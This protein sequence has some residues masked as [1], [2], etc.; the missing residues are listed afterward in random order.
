MENPNSQNIG[1]VFEEV[2]GIFDRA[3]KAIWAEA[4]ERA[5]NRTQSEQQDTEEDI[6]GPP[7]PGHT[8]T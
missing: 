4:R 7:N 3:A 1:A 2:S 5:A 6:A 8:G